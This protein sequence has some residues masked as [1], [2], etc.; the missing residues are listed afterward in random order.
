MNLFWENFTRYPRFFISSLT[1]LIVI[2]L[3]PII[4]F[5]R[6]GQQTAFIGI[7]IVTVILIGIAKVLQE[8][9]NI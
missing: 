1:G 9:L 3:N 7:F 6:K 8:M 2:I 5:F 4:Q